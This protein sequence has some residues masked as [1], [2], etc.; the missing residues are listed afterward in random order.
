MHPLPPAP[1][2]LPR[3]LPL[4]RAA[5]NQPYLRSCR[6]DAFQIAALAFLQAAR[7][8]DPARGPFPAYARLRVYGALSAW[9]RSLSRRRARECTAA[10]PSSPAMDRPDPAASA[11][12]RAADL[13]ADLSP[14]SP[15]TSAASSSSPTRSATPRAKPPASSASPSRPSRACAPAP[16]AASAGASPPWEKNPPST[17]NSNPTSPRYNDG[18]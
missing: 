1:L 3:F 8:Y 17:Y 12:L 9:Y 4:L 10:N 7:T 15:P 6:E 16:S 13:R 18:E 5:S 2:L 14:P 11:A